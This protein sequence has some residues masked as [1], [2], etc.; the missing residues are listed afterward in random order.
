MRLGFVLAGTLLTVASPAQ[1]FGLPHRMV[2]A[3]EATTQGV[4]FGDVDG[5]GDLDAYLA[6]LGQDRLYLNEEAGVFADFTATNLPALIDPTNAVALGD[7]DGDGDPDAF[8][9]N[10]GQSRLLRNNS[11][12]TFAEVTATNLPTLF[13]NALSVALGDVDGDGAL[14][15]YVGVWGQDR[16][17][18]NVGAGVFVDVSLTSLPVVTDATRGVALGDVDGDGDLDAF[19]GNN[20]GTSVALPNQTRLYENTGLGVFL[21][22][23]ATNLPVPSLLEGPGAVALADMDGDGDLDALGRTPYPSY[24]QVNHLLLNGG[25]GTFTDASTNFPT[26]AGNLGTGVAV[27]DV[28]G[29]G[30]LDAILG[31]GLFRN[32]SGN[33]VFTMAG[34]ASFPPPPPNATTRGAGL[35]DVD[36]DGDLDAFLAA[37][38]DHLLL[39]DG[40]GAF[41]DVSGTIY[42]PAP[43]DDEAI[44]LGDVDADGDLD[45]FVGV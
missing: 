42:L 41:V 4:A 23:S 29:N 22:V 8:L 15:A 43:F 45:A 2:P 21:D 25:P 5:D 36:G 10:S 32:L 1:R 18:L 33:A 39:N 12:G 3:G 16:L 31:D 40:A 28:D 19:T 44:A 9:A 7:V 13:D 11:A 34:P 35:G 17:Y 14:G 30:S 26:G 6:I 24:A 37:R 20:D 38:E 27:G